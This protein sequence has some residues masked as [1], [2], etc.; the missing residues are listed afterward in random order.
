MSKVTAAQHLV[1]VCPHH[2]CHMVHSPDDDGY[3]VE[4]RDCFTT[5]PLKHA[6]REAYLAFDDAWIAGELTP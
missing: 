4:C 5:G 3:Y 6:R 1:N 2:S